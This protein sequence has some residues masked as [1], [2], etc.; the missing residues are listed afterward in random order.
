V[1]G[2]TFT[3]TI[4]NPGAALS[5][6]RSSLAV[7]LTMSREPARPLDLLWRLELRADAGGP[8][9]LTMQ[10]LFNGAKRPLG[11]A[12]TAPLTTTGACGQRFDVAVGRLT[13]EVA[14]ALVY[15]TTLTLPF[16]VE[17]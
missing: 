15:E 6:S 16:H 4:P 17:P 7:I 12:L 1:P 14:G 11:V 3:G 9:C 2:F 8:V 10:D 13:V 5:V